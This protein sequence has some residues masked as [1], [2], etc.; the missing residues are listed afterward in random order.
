M[1][2]EEQMNIELISD[3]YSTISGQIE[4]LEARKEELRKRIELELPDE[5]YTATYFKASWV[6]KK[7]YDSAPT[8]K[9]LKDNYKKEYDL[10]KKALDKENFKYKTSRY[11]KIEVF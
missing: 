6:P 3:E 10:E 2:T 8:L 1:Q 4:R 5:G 7:D 11:L 9:K